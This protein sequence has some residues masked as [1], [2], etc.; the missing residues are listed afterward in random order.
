MIHRHIYTTGV[1]KSRE[2]DLIHKDQCDW[3]Y[4]AFGKYNHHNILGFARISHYHHN[5]DVLVTRTQM[6]WLYNES[7]MRQFYHF[8]TAL[9]GCDPLQYG[10]NGRDSVSNHQP[11][12]CLLNRL[13]CGDRPRGAGFR[14]VNPAERWRE[15]PARALARARFSQ[16]L[17]CGI[18]WSESSPDGSFALIPHPVARWAKTTP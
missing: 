6:T 18:H 13:F 4:R 8:P 17:E 14:S 7:V 1:C 5:M 11:R 3:K 10:H 2:L 12:D 15:N 16:H 9:V